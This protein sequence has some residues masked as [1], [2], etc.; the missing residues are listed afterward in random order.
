MQT[1]QHRFFVNSAGK[2][3]PAS[4]CLYFLCQTI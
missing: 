2:C 3:G 1:Y 4:N